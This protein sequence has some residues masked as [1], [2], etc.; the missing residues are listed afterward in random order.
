M[1]KNPNNPPCD[2]DMGI[3]GEF[4]IKM[5]PMLV[6]IASSFHNAQMVDDLVQHM[7]EMLVESGHEQSRL[8]LYR[9]AVDYMRK[10]QPLQDRRRMRRWSYEWMIE[11]GWQVGNEL[12]VYEPDEGETE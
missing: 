12:T 3:E 1:E 10:E 2:D 6:S 8:W 7:T 4:V 5:R 11:Q 9:R